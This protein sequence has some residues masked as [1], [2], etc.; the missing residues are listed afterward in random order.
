MNASDFNK[1]FAEER[2][3]AHSGQPAPSAGPEEV[4]CRVSTSGE[5]VTQISNKGRWRIISKEG[6]LYG[7]GL[8]EKMLS[9]ISTAKEISWYFPLEGETLCSQ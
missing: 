3:V 2:R 8:K 6:L 4:W 7:K 9:N 5:R 1:Q